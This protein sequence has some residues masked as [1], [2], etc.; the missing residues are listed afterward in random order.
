MGYAHP[1]QIE[2][3]TFR[4]PVSVSTWRGQWQLTPST[5]PIRV[6]VFVS[7]PE[8]GNRSNFPERCFLAVYNYERGTKPMPSDSEYYTP[9]SEPFSLL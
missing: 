6:G 3:T 5:G 1:I 8:D 7:S 4:K 9:S 2:N